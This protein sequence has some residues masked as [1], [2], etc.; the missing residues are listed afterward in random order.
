MMAPKLGAILF[1]KPILLG[2][3][4]ASDLQLLPQ[5]S[6]SLK[7]EADQFPEFGGFLSV[8]P[9]GHDLLD[10]VELVHVP[11]RGFNWGLG[12]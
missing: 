10:V 1:L 12:R 8:C 3:G 7:K 6:R 9:E 4:L 2:Y 5:R 11:S